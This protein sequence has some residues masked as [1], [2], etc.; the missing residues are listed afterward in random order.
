[1]NPIQKT[2][3]DDK[4]LQLMKCMDVLRKLDR[5][6]PGQVSSAFLYIASHNPCHKMAMEYELDL[7][8]ASASR[9]CSYLSDLDRFGKE[10]MG[11][12]IKYEDPDNRK[13]VM[14]KLSA[15]GESIIHHMKSIL[16]D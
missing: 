4:A 13:L 7:S 1:M 14:V 10:G 15:F 5:E 6:F 11:L 3:T 16:W 8:S 9:V 2:V 12:I